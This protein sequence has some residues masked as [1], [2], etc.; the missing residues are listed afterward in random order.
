MKNC[1]LSGY[2]VE[3]ARL[4]SNQ[5]PLACEPGQGTIGFPR[6]SGIS[7]DLEPIRELVQPRSF[8]ISAVG[9]G[10]RNGLWPKRR[11][12]DEVVRGKRTGWHDKT[13]KGMSSHCAA[14]GRDPLEELLL[15]LAAGRLLK[16]EQVAEVPQLDVDW[17]YIR[18]DELGA[19]RLGG[20]KRAPIRFEASTLATRLREIG[21]S[22]A[23][24]VNPRAARGKRRA[25]ASSGKSDADLLPIRHRPPRGQ[26]R[27]A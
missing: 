14:A 16:A 22:A 19:L 21:V 20:G 6:G 18:A 25:A 13:H 17:V 9:F 27:A 4:V 2:V 10:Q 3:W 23:P 1:C 11:H 7:A 26:G 5:R 8:R 24:A 15:T 12:T